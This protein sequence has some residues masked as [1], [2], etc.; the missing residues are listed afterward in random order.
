M[1][2]TNESFGQ[3]DVVVC[4][5]IRLA[6]N[7][8]DYPFVN[9]CS[10]EQLAEIESTVRTGLTD[11]DCLSQLS[12]LDSTEME[13]LERQFLLDLETIQ[14]DKQVVQLDSQQGNSG[15]AELIAVVSG[16]LTLESPSGP[17]PTSL[18]D[19][20]VAINEEDHL[21]LTVTRG[22]LDLSAAWQ[23]LGQLD[24]M[25]EGHFNFAFS[26]RWGYLTACPAN[27]GT[28]MRVSVLVH[29]P[30]LVM[31]GQTEKVFRSVQRVNVVARGMF[32]DS[33]VGDFFRISNQA[34]LGCNEADLIDQVASVIPTLVRCE[35]E[36]REFLLKENTEAVHDQVNEAVE[37]L[38]NCD[39]SDGSDEN[40]ELIMSLLSK[41]RL[42]VGLGVLDRPQ[43]S[44]VNA[45]FSLVNLRHRLFAA[46]ARED[47]SEASKLRDQIRE[48]ETATVGGLG[49]SDLKDIP[50]AD[51]SYD[52]EEL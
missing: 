26:P 17:L 28:G 2:E 32:G 8:A 29:L 16:E 21:R 25:I 34:T 40:N 31:T 14:R 9:T 51:S 48:L 41:V 39:L 30:A 35:R 20:S 44:R 38:C 5:R 1:T 43:I 13:S 23:Q 4:S 10:T 37:A 15:S 33:A 22:D 11:D 19:L 12:F 27:V 42:G 45:L 52:K 7:I 24:D 47:Y 50:Q 18:D 6:R 36:A 46:V 3:N 49:D